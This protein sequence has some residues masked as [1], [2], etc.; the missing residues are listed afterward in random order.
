MGLCP[1]PDIPKQII[2]KDKADASGHNLICVQK[3]I[4]FAHNIV[5]LYAV[6]S[7]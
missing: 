7:I 5:V 2:R 6:S 3:I 4:S 1:F